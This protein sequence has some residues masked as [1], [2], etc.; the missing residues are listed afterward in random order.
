MVLQILSIHDNLTSL[1]ICKQ[2]TYQEGNFKERSGHTKETF[3]VMPLSEKD[4]PENVS[5]VGFFV[6]LLL[7]FSAQASMFYVILLPPIRK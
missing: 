2:D 3:E 4:L 5:L 6:K 1:Q 7:L